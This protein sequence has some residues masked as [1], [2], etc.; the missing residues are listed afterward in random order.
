MNTI[1]WDRLR[2]RLCTDENKYSIADKI[3]MVKIFERDIDYLKANYQ[4]IIDH[5]IRNEC[6][7]VA[8]TFSNE[9]KIIDFLFQK[10][11]PDID[12]IDS[13]GDNYLTS[14]CRGNTTKFEII[15]HIIEI[16]KIN[17][18][19]V[20]FDGHDFL[21]TALINNT[22]MSFIRKLFENYY[23]HEQSKCI[24][25]EGND[26]LLTAC[27]WNNVAIIKFL[28]E[29]LKMDVNVT[30][31]A[32]LN[33]FHIVIQNP[34]TECIKYIINNTNVT[35]SLEK[36][37]IDNFTKI[38]NL[39]KDNHEKF[40]C[41]V[42]MGFLAYG[43]IET[44]ISI[45]C[46]EPLLLNERFRKLIGS[47][48]PFDESFDDFVLRVD[49]IPHKISPKTQSCY[50]QLNRV[51]KIHHNR[52]NFRKKI[53]SELL[54]KHM[55]ES[56]YGSKEIVYNA[57][58]F[59]KGIFNDKCFKFDEDIMIDTFVPTYI[60]DLYIESCYTHFLNLD[61]IKPIDFVPFLRFIDQY[62]T[63]YLAI[64]LIETQLVRYIETNSIILCDYIKSICIK[65]Q[66]KYMYLLIHNNKYM[67]RLQ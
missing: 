31:L 48:D 10:F 62:P 60:M 59:L 21:H 65:Y 49:S 11:K 33:C 14:A 34:D 61:E 4:Q 28:V 53:E 51:E 46:I 22:N 8:V 52:N 32:G 12:F 1:T 9:I 25:N 23:G 29:D 43:I 41:L 16:Y 37:S 7:M 55:D 50:D 54:F 63:Y 24:D 47:Y 18:N 17:V 58:P 6:F 44:I 45:A 5:V 40:V 57:I 30:N 2:N 64:N 13:G 20:D 42:D 39:I 3:F 38:I 26:Y 27:G 66:L 67:M 15:K 56:Y 19:Y 36:V 35:I